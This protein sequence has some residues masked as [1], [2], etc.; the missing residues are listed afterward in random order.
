M[1]KYFM[2]ALAAT[3]GLFASCSSEDLT[4]GAGARKAPGNGLAEIQLLVGSPSSTTRGTGTVG[5]V[6]GTDEN[7]WGGQ[8]FN[9]LMLEKGTLTYSQFDGQNIYENA[10]F[11]APN[12]L[13]G[14]QTQ[15]A[16]QLA[17]TAEGGLQIVENVKYFPQTG[18]HD[19]WAYRMD[20]THGD[21]TDNAAGDAKEITFTI[22]GSNDIMVAKAI[23]NVDANEDGT[24]G[25]RNVPA[26]SLF[27]AFSVRRGVSPVLTFQHL[28]TRLVFKVKAS[29]A[30]S[31]S[32]TNPATLTG[33]VDNPNAITVT[34]IK[35]KSKNSGKLV[36]A[37]TADTAPE[38]ITWDDTQDDLSLQQRAKT[39]TAPATN[40]WTENL[41]NLANV[42]D[43]ATYYDDANTAQGTV[44]TSNDM[45]VY[46]SKAVDSEG[47]PSGEY[48]ALGEALLA[49]NTEFYAYKELTATQYGEIDVNRD[50]EALTPQAAYWDAT[51]GESYPTQVGEALLVAPQETYELTI[52]LSQ[53]MPSQ[54]TITYY[55][56][57]KEIG[58]HTYYFKTQAE[59]EAAEAAGNVTGADCRE[60]YTEVTVPGTLTPVATT[61]TI[62]LKG[63]KHSNL[64]GSTY[65][66]FEANKTYTVTLTLNGVESISQ[67]TQ[68]G[69][70]EEGGEW[71]VD[72]DDPGAY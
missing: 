2:F 6:T 21:P 35:V 24:Y 59:A 30:L 20:G 43:A 65:D 22:D 37:Y 23:A 13:G 71:N 72:L 19:F 5:G 14:V 10:V 49:G 32:Y 12:E 17:S 62:T 33:G 25:A 69:G 56:I 27:S 39:V 11:T 29:E 53:N 67:S 50:L 63:P 18:A 4:E 48:K 15:V 68:I 70:Y 1:K 9:V 66:P 60:E 31:K 54:N 55:A 16:R 57:A 8:E 34:A 52:E 40:A 41:Y 36:V 7:K 51:N 46:L 58:G 61:K 47:H 45:I 28:L 38:F 44:N 64:G 26:D 42:G 3:A